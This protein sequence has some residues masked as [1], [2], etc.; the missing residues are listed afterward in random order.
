[1]PVFKRISKDGLSVRMALG[2]SAVFFNIIIFQF[3]FQPLLYKTPD[4]EVF[5]KIYFISALQN[6]VAGTL[7][8]LLAVSCRSIRE[9][10]KVYLVCIVF[11][12]MFV[13]FTD[14]K[15]SYFFLL[16][17]FIAFDFF[18]NLI[19]F[20]KA[21]SILFF[22]VLFDSLLPFI[23][24][25]N[26]NDPVFAFL[27][28][29][30][31]VCMIS[32]VVCVYLQ[33]VRCISFSGASFASV[34]WLRYLFNIYSCCVRVVDKNVDKLVFIVLGV[35]S[36]D[37]IP[38]VVV[39]GIMSLPVAL[40]SRLLVV[41][42]VKVRRMSK[43]YVWASVPCFFLLCFFSGC[44]VFFFYGELNVMFLMGAFLVRYT[45]SINQIFYAINI[46]SWSGNIYSM[47]FSFFSFSLM[48]VWAVWVEIEPLLWCV[49]LS[50]YF[51]IQ[52]LLD[53][54]EGRSRARS[55]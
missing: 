16:L 32:L 44:I 23:L 36:V 31:L 27:I 15:L 10:Y 20:Y 19:R 12:L 14:L 37:L 3:L 51:I 4:Y 53:F 7:G 25:L 2:M 34:T 54:S 33:S 13:V 35:A 42:N 6:S 48:F 5:N 21:E 40:A 1:M 22:L 43:R 49:I 39:A 38:F 30:I 46:V 11:S 29:K 18:V 55:V 28:S 45:S 26:S 8:V 9:F 50:G 17:G 52:L 47:V 24:F 41:E